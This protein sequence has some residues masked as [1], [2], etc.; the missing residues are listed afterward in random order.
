LQL[1]LEER[2][3]LML[4]DYGLHAVFIDMCKSAQDEIIRREEMEG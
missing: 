3:D 4:K 2:Y 1:D